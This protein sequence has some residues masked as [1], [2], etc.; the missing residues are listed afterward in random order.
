MEKLKPY[1]HLIGKVSDEK[2]AEMAGLSLEELAVAKAALEAEKPVTTEENREAFAETVGKKAAKLAGALGAKPDLAPEVAELRAMLVEE[3]AARLELEASHRA[4]AA[5]HNQ[6]IRD[7]AVLRA[8][9]KVADLMP[10][11]P[12]SAPVEP[13]PENGEAREIPTG[14]AVKVTRNA[15]IRGYQSKATTLRYGDILT[16]EEAAWMLQNHPDLVKVY[17]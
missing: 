16:G 9:M 6:A 3:R 5:S 12:A 10:V 14:K 17:G 4:L 15:R 2:L 8:Q 13:L 11:R 7:I 1:V